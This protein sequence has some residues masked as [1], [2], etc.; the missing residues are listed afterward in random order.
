MWQD[1]VIICLVQLFRMLINLS[2]EVSFFIYHRFS[3]KIVVNVNVNNKGKLWDISVSQMNSMLYLTLF[4]QQYMQKKS[5]HV[6]MIF[7]VFKITTGF[8]GN[9]VV[10]CI[11][12]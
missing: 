3:C 11:D 8:G 9:N 6:L 10:K 1:N 12:T 4:F 7:M 5:E 2:V